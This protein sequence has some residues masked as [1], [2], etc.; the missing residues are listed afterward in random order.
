MH[1][2]LIELRN[3]KAAF[4]KQ[5]QDY[6][7]KA[8]AE[9]RTL[10]VDEDKASE[11]AIA[12][13]KRVQAEID[14]FEAQLK[15]EEERKAFLAAEQAALG[16]STGVIA[17]RSQNPANPANTVVESRA[18][19]RD[20]VLATAATYGPLKNFSNDQEG[21][22][23]AYRF[24]M[25]C[26]VGA[27]AVIGRVQR[28]HD[29]CREN[30][31]FHHIASNDR[32]ISGSQNENT[33]FT[34]GYLVPDEFSNDLID[35]RERY[36]VFSKYAKRI[37]MA[38]ETSSRPR[39]TGGLTAYFV[40]ENSAGTKSNKTWDRVSL[41]AKKIMCISVWSRE[42]NEDAVI[43]LGDD[44]AGEIAYAFANKQDQCGFNGDGTSTYG[45]ML[46]IIPKIEAQITASG[47]VAHC[48]Q[49]VVASSATWTSMTQTDFSKV[50]GQL[51]DMADVPGQVAWFCHR[52]FAAQTFGR[53]MYSISGNKKEDLTGKVPT[54]FMGYPVVTTQVMP[55]VSAATT[56]ECLLGN[57]N[58][59]ADFGVRREMDLSFSEHATVGS[60]NL[61]EKEAMAIRG[62]ARFDINVHDVGTYNATETSR[63]MSPVV[64]LRTP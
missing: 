47:N 53:L 22:Y 30:G 56:I 23:K 63:I 19:K 9:N 32:A 8:T 31:L 6:L 12:E 42:L 28:A 13:S 59:A 54:E 29:F 18:E 41:I 4:L 60:D 1:P 52:T 57:L 3:K 16:A 51:L 7:D 14:A 49:V 43:N 11:T 36:G 21:R 37:P 5:A 25:W 26:L 2:K 40:G 45:G 64:A 55:R 10:T 35:L 62:S 44:L 33:N 27:A 46:G 48:P 17:A 61:W 24:G 15:K 58:L 38:R 39:R 34:G 20:R 50:V